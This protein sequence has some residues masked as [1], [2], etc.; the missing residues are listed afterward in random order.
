MEKPALAAALAVMLITGTPALALDNGLLNGGTC[1]CL[2]TA[3]NVESFVP[4]RSNFLSCVLFEGRT[5]NIQNPETQLIETGRTSGCVERFNG[6][7]GTFTTPGDPQVPQ[8]QVAPQG[9]FSQ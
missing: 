9:T 4:Y 8:L 3:P 2:C 5:C 1:D 7:N 6:L